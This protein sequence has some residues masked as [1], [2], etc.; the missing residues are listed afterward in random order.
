MKN[1]LPEIEARIE[2][3]GYDIIAITETWLN[4]K[5]LDS[6]VE[7]S[8]YHMARMDRC[9][10]KRGGGLIAYVK[11]SFV[12][13]LQVVSSTVVENSQFLTIF[14]SK[15]NIILLVLYHPVWGSEICHSDYT[16]KIVE[17]LSKASS[18]CKCYKYV[19]LG[20]F[21]GL[22][23]HFSS[24]ASMFGLKNIVNFAT[25][26]AKTLDCVYTNIEALNITF[27]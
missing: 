20:D 19:V 18:S 22:S 13:T 2:C 1:K 8:G 17:I 26:N 27:S 16:D 10:R 5:I 7:F 14:L 24:V 4:D 15:C 11:K 9:G 21:N 25:R 6:E 12:S 3:G 23:D